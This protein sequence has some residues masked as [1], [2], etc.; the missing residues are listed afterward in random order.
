MKSKLI[1]RI[2]FAAI[3][4]TFVTLDIQ[5]QWTPPSAAAAQPGSALTIPQAE[6]IQPEALNHLLQKAGPQKPLVLQVGS[7][8][9]FAQAHIPGAEYVGPGS[10]P[11]GLQALRDRVSSLARNQF[12]VLY[13][14]C[15]PW[16][17]CPNIEPALSKLREMGFT[18]VKVLYLADNFGAGW[19]NKGYPVEQGR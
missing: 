4:L 16:N 6:L 1:G 7:H 12:I 9:L 10:Q 3:L 2:G 13:C 14:G 15:C 17:H 5:A 19:V 18:N 8:V 11:G